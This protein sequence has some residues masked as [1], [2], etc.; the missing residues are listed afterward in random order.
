M[1]FKQIKY[2]ALVAILA[3]FFCTPAFTQVGAYFGQNKVQYK[4]FEWKVFRTDHFD[5]HYYPEEEQAAHD[6]ARMVERGY[7]YLSEVLDHRIKKRIPLILY[8]SLN[9]FQQT[10][11]IGG[12]LGQGTRGVTE[13]LQNRVILPITGSY[14]E[15]HHVLVHEL[16][17]AFQ[18]DMMLHSKD[19]EQNNR[20]NPPL[21]FVE[22]MAEYLSNGMDNTTRMWVRDGLTHGHLLSVEQLN[23]AF[24]IRVYRLG[25]SLWHYIGE[26][27]GK[28]IVGKIFKSAVRSGSMEVALTKHLGI[29]LKQLTENWH[30]Y[31][32]DMAIP[33]DS[34]LQQPEDIAEKL[35]RQ[36]SFYHR[37]N[38]APSV[39]PDGKH[40]VFVANRNLNDEIY[41]LSETEDGEYKSQHLV[42][43]G[44]GK[45]FE[46]LRFF[47]TTIGWSRDGQL[48]TFVSKSG[49][50]DVIYVMDP[51]QKKL[52]K[53]LLFKDLNGLTS[54]TFSPE[55]DKLAFVGISGGISDL[56][57]VD[58]ET[59]A[60]T[61]LTDD[62]YTVLHPN[63]SPDGRSIVFSSDR[64]AGT[65][66]HKLLF[67]DY[68]LAVFNLET[69]S[70][71]TI[72]HLHGTVINPQWSPDGREV[73]FISDHHGIP[74][75]Y[76]MSLASKNITR[77]T[78]LQSGISGIT[79]S[80]PAF[81]WS[82]D[83]NVMVF[84]SFYKNS[85]H[86][87]KLDA[88]KLQKPEEASPVLA[89]LADGEAPGMESPDAPLAA[90]ATNGATA[91]VAYP[92]TAETEVGWLPGLSDPNNFYDDYELEP[93]DS[94][95]QRKYSKKMRLNGVA[96]GGGYSS[97]FGVTGGAAFVFSDMLGDR[98]LFFSTG[99]RFNNP[100]HSDLSAT[101]FDQGGRLNWGFQAFQS[102]I[103]YLNFGSINQLG[104]IRNTYRGFNGLVA[105]PFNRFA[106]VE[107]S[108]GVTWV[109][110]DQVF[111]TFRSSGIDRETFDISTF[112]FGQVGAALVFDNTTYGLIGPMAGSR[113]RFSVEQIAGDFDFTFASVD[114]RR[115]F[116]ISSRSA[117]AW[118]FLGAGSF[119]QDK[120]V[121]G[122]GGPY[123]YRGADFNEL[124][125]SKFFVNNLE[126]RFPMLP[127]LP[128][129]YDM[130]LGVAFL[131]AAAAWDVPGVDNSFRPFDTTNGLR[132]DDLNAALGV[133]ARLNLG[134]FLL[135][136]DVAWPTDLGGFDRAVKRFSIGTFF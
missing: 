42:Q 22:G 111:E 43:G 30:A 83:G 99:L 122:I 92:E 114:Y 8:A 84:S 97:F 33:K 119:G 95:E 106:R 18:F 131:D 124:F 24:D 105:Y 94:I 57:I 21:W 65:D 121:Y 78:A 4:N 19:I 6:A 58:I 45:Q 76:R 117:L 70:I 34:T 71:E 82:G 63:W 27:H 126:Y 50:N 49:K 52:V 72:T 14:R 69:K 10:N 51:H 1:V 91:G 73:A 123:T 67:G 109:D 127:F 31:A 133:G 118:R 102:N 113:S 96:L 64:G 98:N 40:I 125:G 115:Y 17:H 3:S 134:Y 110:Q 136:F 2:V 87:Y 88:E 116:R 80:T 37:M 79:E 132:L 20:F 15:F 93:S 89:H 46:T 101:Y 61:Q 86:L 23:N 128:P 103:E 62:K 77:V 81:S 7:D 100:L 47:D 130:L 59:E 68:D 39:S 108:A 54:P 66:K 60:L 26:T 5:V 28:E 74:N 53:K 48:I 135:G 32:R 90:I 56:Y 11:V 75:I 12:L 44:G 35:T 85:W 55:G 9:D 41:L 25:Q 29:K 104:F 38:I 16:V 112:N 13:G 36:Q 129:Q 120:Q 107:L